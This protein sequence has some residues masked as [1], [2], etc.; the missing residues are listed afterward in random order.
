MPLVTDYDRGSRDWPVWNCPACGSDQWCE[1]WSNLIA[2]PSL[3]VLRCANPECRA[4][5]RL[6][7]YQTNADRGPDAA[8]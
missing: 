5:W 1:P 8:E 3:P 6:N 2:S 4:E 7:F